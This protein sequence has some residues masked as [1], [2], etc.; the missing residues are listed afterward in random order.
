VSLIDAPPLA[1]P[2][3]AE[4][5]RTMLRL[6]DDP[7]VISIQRQL[8]EELAATPTG[9]TPAGA[10]GIDR[11]VA[12]WTANCVLAEIGTYQPEPAFLW[13]LDNTPRTWFGHT[14]PG[15]ASAGDNPDF[16]YRRL[17]LDGAGSYEI[18]G[19]FDL[20]NRPAQF[21]L[22]V[23][24]GDA[25]P[26]PEGVVETLPPTSATG[27][28]VSALT[29]R[30]LTIGPDGSFTVRMGPRAAELAT[31]PG[32]VN[33]LVRD[34]LVD[35]AQRPVSLSIR[36]LDGAK[37]RQQAELRQRVL[38]KLRPFLRFWSSFHQRPFIGGVGPNTYAGPLPRE[39]GWGFVAGGRFRL[40]QDEALL[41]TTSA[42]SAG[43]TG[44]QVTDP[45]T[46]SSDARR[47]QV[48]LNLTQVEPD[49]NGSCTFLVA[50]TDPGTANWIDT[51][52]LA[53]GLVY[54]RWQDMPTGAAGD[55]LIRDYRIIT[56][57]DAAAL[58]GVARV[59]PQQR[60]E[61]LAARAAAY[62]LRAGQ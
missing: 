31:V 41:V 29:D 58:P 15:T 21:V 43:Y 61:R 8:C 16:I 32:K 53:E 28:T 45:W 57:D 56:L 7:D 30:D 39:G 42:G 34:A 55:G 22:D 10:A 49:D 47:K 52:G 50:P 27:V 17:T 19:Q 14:F 11:A 54:L 37:P 24:E 20:G 46:I 13:Q 40:A 25:G 2:A 51:D 12:R 6:L 1:T 33:L 4:A 60:Q 9:K 18:S 5:E 62:D 38:E 59:T 35:W 36:R 26:P 48:S 23:K 3:Q 44:F